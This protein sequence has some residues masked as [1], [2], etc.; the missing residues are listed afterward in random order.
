ML[1]E[2]FRF[3]DKADF[4]ESEITSHVFYYEHYKPNLSKSTFK[5]MKIKQ[6]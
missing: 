3:F 6:F 4:H 2:G 5:G 1:L